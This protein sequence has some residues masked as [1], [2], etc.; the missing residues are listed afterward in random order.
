MVVKWRSVLGC[1]V[2]WTNLLR[3]YMYKTSP[4]AF[5][6]SLFVDYNDMEH[7]Q[8][9]STEVQWFLRTI[10]ALQAQDVPYEDENDF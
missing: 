5:K 9:T 8:G 2:N 7:S 4:V 6:W 1:D 10:E 3:S